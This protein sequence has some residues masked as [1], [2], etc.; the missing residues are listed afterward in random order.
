MKFE[1][2]RAYS[3]RASLEVLS[4]CAVLNNA[5][6]VFNLYRLIFIMKITEINHRAKINCYVARLEGIG[7]YNYFQN[8]INL[9]Q[10]SAQ[11]LCVV[12]TI[13]YINDF[14]ERKYWKLINLI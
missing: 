4:V 10:G 6:E 8:S 13:D 5:N 9:N 2:E 12:R 11:L 14:S 3:K 7:G 1:R